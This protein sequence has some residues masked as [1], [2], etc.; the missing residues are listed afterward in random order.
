M[1]LKCKINNQEYDITQGCT[2]AEEYNETL[3][4]GSIII[5]Q[6]AQIKDLKPFDDVFIYDGDFNGYSIKK[7]S[8]NIKTE[9]YSYTRSSWT[10]KISDS[11]DFLK[12]HNGVTQNIVF[13]VYSTLLGVQKLTLTLKWNGISFRTS[14][15]N[16][17][18]DGRVLTK[19]D[20]YYLVTFNRFTQWKRN[21]IK[22][23]KF[24]FTWDV[25]D[26]KMPAFYKHLLVDQFTEEIVNIKDKIYRYKIEL[27]SETKA[28]E[29]I[30]LP[31]ISI[32]QPLSI[33]KKKSVYSYLEDFIEIYSPVEKIA[34]DSDN[35][36][37]NKKYKLDENLKETFDNVYAPDFSLNNPSLKDLISNLM[38]VKDMIP[39]VKD[40]VI[41][42]LDIS[43]RR[44]DFNIDLNAITSITGSRSSDNH[45]DNLRRQYSDALSQDN[46]ARS[47]EYMGFRNSDNCLM[48]LDNMR[49]ET[50]FPIYKINKVYMCYYKKGSIK[51]GSD[52]KDIMFLCK[53]DITQLVLLNSE[54]NLL[55]KDYTQF[56]ETAPVSMEEMATYQLCTLGYDIGS[57]YIEGWGTNYSYPKSWFNGSVTRTYIENLI[58]LVDSF[59]PYGIYSYG[60]LKELL[61]TNSVI[62]IEGNGMENVIHSFSNTSLGLKSFFFIVDYQGFYNG[63]IIHSK[64]DAR[65]DITIADNS[66]S[67]LTLLERDGIFEKEKANRFG[68][69][70]IIITA[71]YDNIDSMQEL[72]SVYNYDNDED[73]IIYHREYAIYD[74]CVNVTYYGTKSYVLRNYFTSVFAKHRTYN[75]MS[76]SESVNRA[77]NK[78]MYILLSK[79]KSYYEHEN[80]AITFANF[81]GEPI[82]KILSF[83]QESP[84]ATSVGNFNYEDRINCAY[85]EHKNNFYYCD[86]NAFV[87]GSSLCF[88]LAMFDN[89]SMG[90]NIIDYEPDTS[91]Y[92]WDKTDDDIK[93]SIQGWLVAVDDTDTGYIDTMGFYVAHI[94]KSSE[95]LDS[96]Q[97]YNKSKI[98]NVFTNKIFKMPLIDSFDTNPTNVIGGTFK[99]N[100]DNKERIDMTYQIEPISTDDNVMFSQWMM[101]L[102][103]LISNYKKSV[104]EY[105]ITD[106]ASFNVEV[107]TFASTCYGTIDGQIFKAPLMGFYLTDEQL[108]K[109]SN[110]MEANT[111]FE[112]KVEGGTP[113]ALLVGGYVLQYKYEVNRITK[114]DGN[115]IITIG[116]SYVKIDNQGWGTGDTWYINNNVQMTFKHFTEL[117]NFKAP[118]GYHYY[119]NMYTSTGGVLNY[120]LIEGNEIYYFKDNKK[121]VPADT[122]YAFSNNKSWW[123]DSQLSSSNANFSK[124][125]L[126]EKEGANSISQTYPKTMYLYYTTEKMSKKLVYNEYA[127]GTIPSNMHLANKSVIETFSLDTDGN[128]AKYLKVNLSSID[129]SARSLQYWYLDEA[130]KNIIEKK[131]NTSVLAEYEGGTTRV[132]NMSDFIK[133]E[134][135]TQPIVTFGVG[136]AGGSYSYNKYLKQLTI[137]YTSSRLDSSSNIDISFIAYYNGNTTGSMKFVFGVNL[138][139]EDLTKGYVKINISLLSTKDTRVYDEHHNLI[140]EVENYASNE[141]E[142]QYGKN[143]YY[144][145]IIK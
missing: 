53:Q 90:V 28:L 13:S 91:K 45:C 17:Q 79:D 121:I 14:S 112:Y 101:K 46:T 110:D 72:G 109:I 120:K 126:V 96:P 118:S 30:Q 8:I 31:N 55:S 24:Q 78:K 2:F 44:S 6:V 86:V 73:V 99:I 59:T 7:Q 29:M 98:N 87:S 139:E 37:F 105:T 3:D 114:F 9:L 5:S 142:K 48:T 15:G 93:G 64:D 95:F 11:I 134:G 41:C 58:E 135:Y 68:N 54:R 23:D 85:I 62:S 94:D 128:G 140:G 124:V 103:D 26:I 43:K 77:E 51:T 108:L 116:T 137:T 47:I 76:Y 34:I 117:G 133:A 132:Y 89:V 82:T 66:S 38:L 104:D 57:N 106:V 36:F 21:S 113:S 65:D 127:F 42:G 107:L 119:A 71:R 69:K 19:Y 136:V 115:T 129:S 12:E 40:G 144:R 32:T 60:Y 49:L 141:S 27:F 102:S 131:V 18:F 56:N 75:L 145:D 16:Q 84:K 67:S 74:N 25:E 122:I 61:G 97:T 35:W 63:A 88:N 50:K 111:I 10:Y 92:I 39:Y 20:G 70:A 123:Q 130:N 52:S 138:T 33:E 100:K 80:N 143:Q 4:S 81:N 125:L 1:K 83:I 22:C